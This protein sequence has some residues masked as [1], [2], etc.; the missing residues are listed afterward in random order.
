MANQDWK[1]W[2][3][4]AVP[5]DENCEL[6]RE[7]I[8]PVLAYQDSMRANYIFRRS[9]SVP[10]RGTFLQERDIFVSNKP[11][12]LYC[13][14]ITH[15]VLGVSLDLPQERK[16]SV[17]CAPERLRFQVQTLHYWSSGHLLRTEKPR[18]PHQIHGDFW[19]PYAK[20]PHLNIYLGFAHQTEAIRTYK[21]LVKEHPE[22][23]LQLQL[24]LTI[25]SN[26]PCIWVEQTGLVKCSLF[27]T[28][29]IAYRWCITAP[30]NEWKWNSF[31]IRCLGEKEPFVGTSLD[32]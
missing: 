26:S 21:V 17:I 30:K 32:A 15:R 10:L 12:L 1:F 29:W 2:S 8:V 9:L 31:F 3:P 18:K 28:E 11:P 25:E 22:F 24:M 6:D 14:K 23:D 20:S 16:I 13:E 4:R 7:M 27:K 5:L 19:K